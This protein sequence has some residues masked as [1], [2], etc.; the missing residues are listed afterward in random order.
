MVEGSS[1]SSNIQGE[2]NSI[3]A[4]RAFYE[5]PLIHSIL[6]DIQFYR[7][8]IWYMDHVGF[9]LVTAF[10]TFGN[11]MTIAVLAGKEMSSHKVILISL[12]GMQYLHLISPFTCFYYMVKRWE[13]HILTVVFYK[14]SHHATSKSMI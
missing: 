7:N 14:N 12:A 2:D 8:T 13:K 1:G 3:A 11:G 9:L 10:G 6:Q 5:A 4:I